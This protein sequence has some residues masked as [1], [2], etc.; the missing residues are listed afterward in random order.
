MIRV[1]LISGE[2]R[3]VKKAYR[4]DSSQKLAIGCTL[5]LLVAAGGIGWRYLVIT[6][7]SKV[8]DTELSSAQLE[9]T[10]LHSII[11]QVQQF[12]QRKA[13]LQQRVSLIEQLRKDQTGP[14]HML[15]QVSRS[16]PATLWLTEL[17]QAA[18]GDDVFIDGKCSTLTAL[19]DFVAS[20]ESSGYFQRSIEIVSTTVEG[21]KEAGEL[22]KFQIK[23]VFRPPVEA[24]H[25]ATAGTK[26][27]PG[28][29]AAPAAQ[30]IQ[31]TKTGA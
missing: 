18:T 29:P 15:D 19:S 3:S 16:L 24:A 21:T 13:Q 7:A 1:N 2:R 8:L 10:R 9:T 22:I 11:E 30:A 4:F 17:K 12:E 31:A 27:V 6:E 28:A 20:L 23:A 25:V 5:I 26:S 14:V